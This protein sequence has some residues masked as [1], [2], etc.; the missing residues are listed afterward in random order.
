MDSDTADEYLKDGKSRYRK[1]VRTLASENGNEGAIETM[2]GN[3]IVTTGAPSGTNTIIGSIEDGLRKKNYFF[4]HNSNGNDSIFEYSQDTETTALVLASPHFK[5][6]LDFLITGIKVIRLSEGNHLLYWTDNLTQPKKINIQKAIAFSSGDFINGYTSSTDFES[7]INRLKAPPLCAPEY[8]WGGFAARNSTSTGGRWSIKA[9]D[10]D[11]LVLLYPVISGTLLPKE[12]PSKPDLVNGIWTVGTTGAYEIRVEVVVAAPSAQSVTIELMK[13]NIILKTIKPTGFLSSSPETF[14]ITLPGE[15]L[16]AGEQLFIR[17]TIS[18]ISILPA[19]STFTVNHFTAIDITAANNVP[20]ADKTP[21]YL[22]RKMYTF[23]YQF[24]YDDFEVSAWSPISK[25]EFPN[26]EG[27]YVTGDNVVA[28]DDKITVCV[29]T[30]TQ[31]VTKIRIAAKEVFEPEFTMIEEVNKKDLGL[32]DN[33]IYSYSFYGNTT[34]VPIEVNE[35]IKLF[36]NTPLK[37]GSLE[38]I[39]PGRLVDGDVTEGFDPVDVDLRLFLRY[40]FR[41]VAPSNTH[42]PGRSYLKSGGEYLF[43]L[44][45]YNTGNQSGTTNIQEGRYDELTRSLGSTKGVYGTTVFLPFITQDSYTPGSNVSQGIYQEYPAIV[46][47]NISNRPPSWATHYQIV[48]TKNIAY[49]EFIQFCANTI[50]YT[51]GNGNVVAASVASEIEMS[52]GNITGAYEDE[53]RDSKITFDYVQGDRIRFIANPSSTNSDNTEARLSFNDVSIRDYNESQLVAFISIPTAATP[54]DPLRAL[55]NGVYY[56]KYTPNI[57][58]SSDQVPTFEIAECHEIGEDSNSNRVHFSNQ[59]NQSIYEFETLRADGSGTFT[60]FNGLGAGDFS[61]GDE[62]KIFVEESYAQGAKDHYN[63]VYAKVL[64]ATNT[65]LY[66]DVS[67]YGG[68]GT[69]LNI[70][71]YI[72]KPSLTEITGGDSFRRR[73]H[74]PHNGNLGLSNI[75][76]ESKWVNNMYISPA[77]DEGRPNRVDPDF[78]E[79]RNPSMVRYSEKLIAGTFINGLSSSFGVNFEDYKSSNGAIRKM[80]ASDNRLTLFFDRKIGNVLVSSVIYNDMQGNNTVGASAIVLSPQVDYFK[81]EYG[82]GEHPESFAVYGNAKYGIDVN[83]GVIWRLSTDGLTPIS[84]IYLMHNYTTDKCKSIL[85]SDK[86]VH[87]YGVYD[88]KFQEYIIAFSEFT[89]SASKIIPGETLGFNEKW[90]EFGSFYDYVPEG[91]VG[92][93]IDI[94]SFSVGHPYRHNT[95]SLQANFY[96]VQYQPELW[97]ILNMEPSNVKIFEAL[98][99]ESNDNWEVYEI[100]TPNGQESNLIDSDFEEKE[101]MQYAAILRDTNT[102]NVALPLIEGDVMRDRTFLIKSRY[103]KTGYNKIFAINMKFIISNLH[104]R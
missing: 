51:D 43:G 39:E 90:N 101:N 104:N 44:V 48:R 4:I 16:T 66:L 88:I 29:R 70:S 72:S 3:T 26:T 79:T 67:N 18:S 37:S 102:P 40:E 6:S 83:R 73:T 50:K 47:A 24:V 71:G 8:S 65:F 21:N 86:K 56:E 1:N 19:P 25:Y 38:F 54:N 92:S 80:Y 23:K 52:T 87:I 7:I 100:T 34:K 96:G 13:G 31:I 89:D 2:D 36:D 32:I 62:V 12:S 76:V 55:E 61:V 53:N 64:E 77:A 85:S 10:S 28:Q 30:G 20:S 9:T 60:V 49:Q 81:G 27:D 78:R 22:L 14:S 63:Y 82:I 11:P 59:G 98:S 99:Q 33:S 94:L 57:D 84:D 58:I 91:L 15:S 45:Y 103:T 46:F 95:N 5:F 68:A 41:R 42:F 75:F 74:I 17:G 97:D 93:G 35:N 69:I